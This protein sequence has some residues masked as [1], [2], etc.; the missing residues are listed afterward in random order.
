MG[1]FSGLDK[2][3]KP[4]AFRSGAYPFWWVWAG[5]QAAGG[6]SAARAPGMVQAKWS[7]CSHFSASSLRGWP[8]SS[9]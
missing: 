2:R 6:Y 3:K 7:V 8:S 4:P 5:E 9:R 1:D